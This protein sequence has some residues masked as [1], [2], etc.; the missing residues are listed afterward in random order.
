[1]WFFLVDITNSLPIMYS[2]IYRFKGYLQRLQWYL[3]KESYH[4]MGISVLIY[5]KLFK[6]Q[7]EVN[8]HT[9]NKIVTANK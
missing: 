1:M 7:E 4:K 8:Y 6:N 3:M 2:L 5:L 9:K